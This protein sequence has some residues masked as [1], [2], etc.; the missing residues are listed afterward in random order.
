MELNYKRY[1][2]VL[3]NFGENTIESEQSGIRPAIIIQNDKGNFFSKTTIVMPLSS[4]IKN[5]K[6]P[7]HTLIRKGKDKGLTCDSMLLGE[8]MRQISE[9]RIKK[10]L[11]SITDIDEQQEIRRVYYANFGE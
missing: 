2:V 6:Q 10:Y 3:V 9:K 4:R 8:C 11:G 5:P 7:T 1:D